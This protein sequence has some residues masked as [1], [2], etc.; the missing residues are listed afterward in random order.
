MIITMV[1]KKIKEDLAGDC[2]LPL[3]TRPFE[4]SDRGCFWGPESSALSYFPFC[5]FPNPIF[6]VFFSHFMLCETAISLVISFAEIHLDLW[7]LYP[8][9]LSTG[10]ILSTVG[11]GFGV[12][13]F[14]PHHT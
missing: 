14:L 12:F 10:V 8:I 3:K 1:I 9:S 7:V 5:I 13:A 6:S 4:P 2:D 11:S